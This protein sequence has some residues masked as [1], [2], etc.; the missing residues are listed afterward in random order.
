MSDLEGQT[1][2]VT[3]ATGGIGKATALALARPGVHLVILGRSEG[4][5][6]ATRSEILAAARETRVETIVCDFESQASIRQ[7]G[8]E[9]LALCPRIDVLVNNAGAIFPKRELTIDGIER[10]FALNHLGY[11]LFTSL[12]LE[13][14]KA[15]APA[16][17]VNVASDAHRT[18]EVDFD[19]LQSTGIYVS[20]RAYSTS[21]LCNILFTYELARRLEGTGV[22]VNCAHPGVV[23]TA[24]AASSPWIGLFFKVARPF[25]RTPEEGAATVVLLAS[26]KEVEGMTGKYFKNGRPTRSSRGSRDPEAARRLWDVSEALTPAS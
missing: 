19:D 7:A 3:G 20:Y 22:T 25:L 16:R 4:K 1:I 6:A 12:L 21:K 26:S 18:G 5:L 11:F 9:C 14:V 2:V 15:S 8:A 23:A 24:F 10:T 13:R 17:I